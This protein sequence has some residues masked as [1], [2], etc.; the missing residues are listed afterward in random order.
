MRD[1]TATN[2]EIEAAIEAACEEFR[3]LQRLGWFPKKSPDEPDELL[4]LRWEAQAIIRSLSD[5]IMPAHLRDYVYGLLCE[6]PKGGKRRYAAGRDQY[7]AEVL[8]DI[9]RRG[10]LP[11]RN[12]AMRD[13]EKRGKPANQSACSVVQKALARI[14]V[15]M[16]ERSIEDIWFVQSERQR[17]FN[18][19]MAARTGKQSQTPGETSG[20]N[21]QVN[22]ARPVKKAR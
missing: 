13:Q 14:G 2:P 4:L 6:T 17:V 7:I 20:K 5:E 16:H 15:H 9:V 8:N 1:T 22:P 10:F 18:G 12:E 3:W 21:N 11:T 19:T